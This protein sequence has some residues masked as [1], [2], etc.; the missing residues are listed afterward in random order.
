[1]SG[2]TSPNSADLK[3]QYAER[4]DADLEAN[5]KE[6]ERISAEITALQEQL[7][8]LEGDRTLLLS[9]RQAIAEDRS[10][11]AP[12]AEG[13]EEAKGGARSGAGSPRGKAAKTARKGKEAKPAGPERG[14]SAGPVLRILAAE[15]LAKH[16]K[17]RS[18]AEVTSALEQA[19]PERRFIDQVV[20]NTLENLVARGEVERIKQKR[21]V[22]YT[23]AG[24]KAKKS[25]ARSGST[26]AAV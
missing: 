10:A 2:D 5:A 7:R 3:A 4:L 11:G 12:G 26:A 22:F 23:T 24:S 18:A 14:K 20:R 8:V 15:E 1:M 9:M 17:P 21:S 6:Q 25:Q 16:S 13:G 19:F